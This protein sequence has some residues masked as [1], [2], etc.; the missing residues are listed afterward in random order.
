MWRISR[1]YCEDAQSPSE[2]GVVPLLFASLSVR[3][4]TYLLGDYKRTL[5]LATRSRPISLL[6]TTE[7]DS[8]ESHQSETKRFHP[9]AKHPTE[10]P[11]HIPKRPRDRTTCG[12]SGQG[13]QSRIPKK[14]C[15]RND[16]FRCRKGFRRSLERR[17]Q[18]KM[19]GIGIRRRITKLKMSFLQDR[20][21][22]IKLEGM[23]STTRTSTA[24]VPQGAVLS[25]TLC[26]IYITHF[27]LHPGV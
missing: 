13:N 3:A 7:Q 4:P 17:T 8:K 9:G 26:N 18:C 14:G 15:N 10:P 24:G 21:F 22:Q 25:T 27:S 19:I 12:Q 2:H 11:I 1:Q 16:P 23:R 5:I 20:I 6:P